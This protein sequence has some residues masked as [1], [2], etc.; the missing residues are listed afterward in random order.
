MRIIPR[1][2][3]DWKGVEAGNWPIWTGHR[4]VRANIQFEQR[5]TGAQLT[6]SL[7]A[8]QQIDDLKVRMPSKNGYV[9]EERRHVNNVRI[10]TQ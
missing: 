3:P 1:I 6:V 10:E 5:G 9:W 4:M 8:G 7:A 2:P